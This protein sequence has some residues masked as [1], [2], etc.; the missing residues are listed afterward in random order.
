M[1]RIFSIAL[2]LHMCLAIQS[3]TIN[4]K[5]VTYRYNGVKNPVF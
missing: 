3:Q 1:Q 5:G 4:Q 2:M